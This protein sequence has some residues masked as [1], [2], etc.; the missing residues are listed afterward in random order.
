MT[1]R[2]VPLPNRT[3]EQ[4]NEWIDEQG[5]YAPGL[6]DFIKAHQDDYEVFFFVTYLYYSTA[7]GLL[8][9]PEKAVLIPT[10][11]D[12]PYIHLGVYRDV[13]CLPKAIVF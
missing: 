4:E 11:H 3:K 6:I 5:P 8:Q 9:A 10:A 12:E 1:A 7:R 13:F 2:I